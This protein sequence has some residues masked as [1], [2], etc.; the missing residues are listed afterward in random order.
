MRKYLIILLMAILLILSYVLIMDGIEIGNFKILSIQE[1][2]QE[3]ENLESDIRRVTELASKTYPN[4]KSSLTENVRQLNIQKENYADLVLFTTDDEVTSAN[5]IKKYEMETIWVTAGNYA[6]KNKLTMKLDVAY[7]TSGTQNVYDLNFTLVGSYI[8]IIECISE[9]ENDSTLG[10]KIE[11]FKMISD[12]DNKL[13][14]T[15]TVKNVSININSVTENVE[16]NINNQNNT[17]SNTTNNNTNSN[18]TKNNTT[19]S[20]TNKVG[21]QT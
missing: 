19:G 8:S 9:I 2:M 7:A 10:F 4:A 18:T 11:N 5:Q 14:A 13:K 3:D 1:I 20:T 17:N 16:D 15:F 12:E 6:T 21:N